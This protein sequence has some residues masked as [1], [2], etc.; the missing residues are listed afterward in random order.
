M[1]RKCI[2]IDAEAACLGSGNASATVQQTVSLDMTIEQYDE[3]GVRTELAALYGIAP[4]Q[5]EISAVVG[6]V[7]LSHIDGMIRLTPHPADASSALASS[8]ASSSSLL[9]VTLCRMR[10]ITGTHV[11]N[12]HADNCTD[13]GRPYMDRNWCAGTVHS[14][15]THLCP[16]DLGEARSLGGQHGAG[17]LT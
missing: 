3:A 13:L 14:W 8:R 17:R 4:E 10:L 15:C 6:S 7:E 1:V 5:I 9:A 16:H 2:N 12:T 11:L